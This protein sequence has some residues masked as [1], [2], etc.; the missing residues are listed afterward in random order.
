MSRCGSRAS[1]AVVDTASK[2][3][4]AEKITAAPRSTP[5]QPYSPNCPVFAGTNGCQLS[6]RTNQIPPAITTAITPTLTATMIVFVV[7]DSRTPT[8]NSSV[9]AHVISTAGRLK[10][11]VTE[12]PFAS[13]T[14]VPGAALTAAGNCSPSCP[15]RLDRCPDQLTATVAAPSAY[16]ST[17][18]HPIIQATSSPSVAY[19]YV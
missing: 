11:A 15:R 16:S 6:A 18:S 5:L 4:N 1:C 19:A 3:M 17:R 14:C 12:P 8:S 2:P 9:T 10:T 7:V 13:I